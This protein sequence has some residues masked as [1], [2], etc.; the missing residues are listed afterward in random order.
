MTCFIVSLLPV[1]LLGSQGLWKLY[2]CIHKPE[3][4]M[5]P[6]RTFIIL[7]YQLMSCD[8][9]QKLGVEW[10]VLVIKMK[11]LFVCCHCNSTF[12]DILKAGVHLHVTCLLG[13]FFIFFIDIW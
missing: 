3:Y 8:S 13:F 6:E 9:L 10:P 7:L 5:V 12:L 2:L 4:K 11:E 1:F